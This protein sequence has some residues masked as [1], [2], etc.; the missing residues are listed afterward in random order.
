ME[1]REIIAEKT[2]KTMGEIYQVTRE[3]SYFNAKE[4]VEL[5]LTTEILDRLPLYA[6]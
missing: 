2:G 3:D 4:A 5:G 1:T 6:I